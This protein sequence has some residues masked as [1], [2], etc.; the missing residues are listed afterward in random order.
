M[1]S[2]R[3]AESLRLAAQA[4]RRVAELFVVCFDDSEILRKLIR[5]FCRGGSRRLLRS[6]GAA[7]RLRAEPDSLRVPFLPHGFLLGILG[8]W[9][10]RRSH[11]LLDGLQ[12][13]SL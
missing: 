4:L 13:P 5:I 12:A 3:D 9:L 11:D 10:I 2:L 1:Y 8:I 6:L 7:A